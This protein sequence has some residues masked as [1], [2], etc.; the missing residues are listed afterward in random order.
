[1]VGLSRIEP[2]DWETIKTG[3]TAAALV[4]TCVLLLRALRTRRAKPTTPSPT[5]DTKSTPSP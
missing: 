3:I 1:M 2:M 4:A 5:K